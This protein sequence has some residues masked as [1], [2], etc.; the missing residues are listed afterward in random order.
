MS[1]SGIAA[2]SASAQ[3]EISLLLR[4]GW[5][6]SGGS[7]RLR[8][9]VPPAG[10][11]PPGGA[12][13]PPGYPARAGRGAIAGEAGDC[14]RG[15]PRRGDARAR[16]PSLH[17]LARPR[18]GRSWRCSRAAAS[19]G[20]GGAPVLRWR[21]R[22]LS[23]NEGL[24]MHARPGLPWGLPARVT[25]ALPGAGGGLRGGAAA[26]QAPGSY[27]GRQDSDP[28]RLGLR[29]A[30]RRRGRLN[31]AGAIAAG[32]GD[33]A[34][35]RDA[36]RPGGAGAAA[37][38]VQDCGGGRARAVTGPA[39]ALG[40]MAGGADSGPVSCGGAGA[41]PGGRGAGIRLSEAARAAGG[42]KARAAVPGRWRCCRGAGRGWRCRRAGPE[43]VPPG[44]EPGAGV[45]PV[46]PDPGVAEALGQFR[47]GASSER[48]ALACLAGNRAGLIP[49]AGDGLDAAAAD[50]TGGAGAAGPGQGLMSDA[51]WARD[52]IRREGA[53][54]G[55]A[56]ACPGQARFGA[57]GMA[58]TGARRGRGGLGAAGCG[59]PE[60]GSRGGLAAGGGVAGC[61]RA[62]AGGVRCGAGRG[63]V[64]VR[65]G[66]V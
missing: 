22:W 33:I 40:K 54:D 43:P 42:L 30:L 12:G 23:L 50:V 36:V 26:V 45:T 25:A 39:G 7:F 59:R 31:R 63:V 35:P 9:V 17:R 66:G 11:R 14:G 60:P 61:G 53:P 29:V 52:A 57:A 5:V 62:G 13:S 18:P 48:G 64:A 19:P 4:G 8:P 34:G 44:D 47:A 28:G 37:G 6:F 58:V 51:A 16:S 10:R 1:R 46:F 24:R 15:H 38:E 65:A 32:V 20:G 56:A 3:I 27:G 2:M 41:V 49:R 21:G 55:P